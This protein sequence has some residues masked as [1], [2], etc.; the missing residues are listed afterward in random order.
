MLDQL[1]ESINALGEEK[2]IKK[3]GTRRD[4]T[5]DNYV[6]LI[7]QA[8]ET[9]KE[10]N[11]VIGVESDKCRTQIKKFEEKL[12]EERKQLKNKPF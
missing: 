7:K 3:E 4:A 1:L 6:K 10:I 8:K 11:S 5:Q 9:K 2:G 12:N